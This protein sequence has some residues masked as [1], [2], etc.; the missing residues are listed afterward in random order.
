M[1]VMLKINFKHIS[2]NKKKGGEIPKFDVRLCCY[3]TNKS[4]LSSNILLLFIK[5]S[6]LKMGNFHYKLLTFTMTHIEGFSFMQSK[7]NS[8]VHSLEEKR[9]WKCEL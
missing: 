5:K 4:L 8:N 6:V 3:E 9:G 7:Y 1:Q 2:D